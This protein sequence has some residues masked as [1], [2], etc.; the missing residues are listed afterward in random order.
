[1]FLKVLLGKWFIFF[2]V[3]PKE[4]GVVFPKEMIGKWLCCHR[5][6][7]FFEF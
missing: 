5:E 2:K 1:M 3:F 7:S 4:H 6:W